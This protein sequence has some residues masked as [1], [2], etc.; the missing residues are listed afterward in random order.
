M[1]ARV[2][3]LFGLLVWAGAAVAAQAEVL[4]A[5]PGLADAESLSYTE[6]IGAVS[7]PLEVTLTRAENP[8]RL[9]FRSVGADLES[10]YRLDPATLVSLSSETLTRAADATVRRTSEYRNL[11]AKPGADDLVVT[12]LGS[13]PVVLRGFPWGRASSAKILYVG[14]T[15]YGSSAISFEL[16]VVG[17]DTVTAAGRTWD[18]WHVTTGL[19]GALSLVMAKTDW[20]FAIE[21]TH[22][23][24]KTSGP[25]G[26]PGSPM[27]TLLLQTF[28]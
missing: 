22:R 3:V 8:A 9:E 27:R 12:D 5:N 10:L 4:I 18:C 6:S 21:G 11:K 2:R 16:Q 26:G 7:R 23:L 1:T 19:G 17:K 25:V 20:W 14:N 15:T 24:I 28:R 13:L